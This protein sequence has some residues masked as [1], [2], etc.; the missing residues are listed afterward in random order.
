[1]LTDFHEMGSEATYFFQPGVQSRTN[2]NTPEMNQELTGRIAERHGEYLDQIG[3][4][5]YTRETFDDFYYGKGSTYPTSTARL[6]FSSSRPPR[7]RCG[8]RRA[9]AS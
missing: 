7:G 9:R 8:R 4:L 6:G 1:V 2:P 3:S 5:Y